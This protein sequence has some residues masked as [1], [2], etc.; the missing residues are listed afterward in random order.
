VRQFDVFDNPNSKARKTQ[1]YVV[2]VQSEAAT[3]SFTVIV[4][5]LARKADAMADTRTV[6]PVLVNGEAFVV[7]FQALAAISRHALTKPVANAAELRERLPRAIDY[8]LGYLN[9]MIRAH[10][11]QRLRVFDLAGAPLR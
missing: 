8:V 6:V 10:E 9:A 5:P 4:A 11:V 1:P 2:V 3:G 7:L